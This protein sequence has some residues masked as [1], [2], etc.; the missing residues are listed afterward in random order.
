MNTENELFSLR[1]MARRLKVKHE[2]LRGEAEAG[3][4]PGVNTDGDWL[5]H[6]PTILR[7]LARRAAGQNRETPRAKGVARGK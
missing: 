4:L 1:P 6:L 5:F 7:L 3:R 2:W